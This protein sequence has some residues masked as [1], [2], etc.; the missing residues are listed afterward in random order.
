MKT[1]IL[2]CLLFA[3]GCGQVVL[4]DPN[5][6]ERFKANWLLYDFNWSKLAYKGFVVEDANGHSKNFDIYSPSVIIKTR[7]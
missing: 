2:I 5:G 3:A 7:D 1:L 6:M 4:K